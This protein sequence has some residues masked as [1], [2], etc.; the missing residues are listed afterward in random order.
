MATWHQQQ[1]RRRDPRRLRALYEPNETGWKV[2][3][4]RLNEFASSIILPTKEDAERYVANVG[5]GMI[6]P[7]RS[8]SHGATHL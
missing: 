3:D 8:K 5:H 4:D 2:V 7:P 1:A 6:I